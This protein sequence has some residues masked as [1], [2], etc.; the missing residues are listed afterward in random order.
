MFSS[1]RDASKVLC[2]RALTT[3]E[4]IL[5]KIDKAYSD[6]PFFKL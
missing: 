2:S 4:W 6:F 1:Q 5:L 3:N